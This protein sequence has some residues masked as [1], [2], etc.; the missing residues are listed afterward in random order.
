VPECVGRCR[1]QTIPAEE[2][3][4]WIKLGGVE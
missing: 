2:L 3:M 4:D 1:I